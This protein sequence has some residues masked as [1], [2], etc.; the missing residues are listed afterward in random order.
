MRNFTSLFSASVY[1]TVSS[2]QI[3]RIWIPLASARS[4]SSPNKWRAD[5]VMRWCKYL[6]DEDPA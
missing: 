1:S 3:V 6:P 4:A 5:A 2:F